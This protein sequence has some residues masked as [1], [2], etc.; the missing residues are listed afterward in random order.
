M[1]A[2]SKQP[3]S[4]V[5]AAR[6][7]FSTAKPTQ[8]QVDYV[9]EKIETGALARGPRG[10]LTTSV[11]AVALYLARRES[12]RGSVY[13]GDGAG[14][15]G[16]GER[17][18]DADTEAGFQSIVKDCFLSALTRR[19]VE[20]RSPVF[21]RAVLTVQ[22]LLLAAAVLFLVGVSVFSL[23]LSGPTAEQKTARQWLTQKYRDVRISSLNMVR[24]PPRA[25]KASFTYSDNENKKVESQL[26]IIVRNNQVVSTYSDAYR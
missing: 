20:N 19:S 15:L 26:V 7:V 17:H 23:G 14:L 8:Q 12:T 22:A 18:I 1:S 10:G 5:E 25:V 21:Q 24:D 2:P 6:R 16:D 11:E 9:V 4:V 13:K 3:L